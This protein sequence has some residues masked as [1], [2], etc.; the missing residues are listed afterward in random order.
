MILS[1]FFSPSWLFFGSSFFCVV[2]DIVMVFVEK[3]W[4]DV[5][6]DRVR[7]GWIGLDMLMSVDWNGIDSVLQSYASDD[8]LNLVGILFA[9]YCMCRLFLSAC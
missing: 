2:W 6:W 8:I 1:F 9:S 3:G 4:D 7:G 5:L